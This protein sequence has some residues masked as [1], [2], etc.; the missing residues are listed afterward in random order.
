MEWSFILEVVSSI[1]LT[2]V[3]LL[4]VMKRTRRRVFKDLDVPKLALLEGEKVQI[5]EYVFKF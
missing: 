4:V 1:G 3:F 5:V 2:L